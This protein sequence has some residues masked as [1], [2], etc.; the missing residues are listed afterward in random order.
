M[1]RCFEAIHK[2]GRLERTPGN[3]AKVEPIPKTVLSFSFLCLRSSRLAPR[4]TLCRSFAG[5]M[6][7]PGGWFVFIPTWEAF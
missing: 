6:N 2:T 7:N 4:S 5:G 3:N 1:D